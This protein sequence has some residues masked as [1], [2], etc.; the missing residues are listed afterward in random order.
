M[1]APTPAGIDAGTTVG[2]V[3]LTVADLQRSLDYYTTSIG[4]RVIERTGSDARLGAGGGDHG[5]AEGLLV[6]DEQPGARPAGSYAGLYHFALLLPDRPSLARWLLHAAEDGVVVG[7][8][9]DHT[10]SEALYLTDPDGHGIEIYRDRPREQWEGRVS[11]LMSTLPLDLDG[12]IAEAS[13]HRGT[14]YPGMPAQTR[15]GHIHLQVADIG[16]TLDFY[17]GV[18]GFEV[19]ARYGAAAAFFGAGGYHHHVGANVWHS[20]GRPVAPPGHATLR[21]ATIVVPGDAELDR[22]EASLKEAGATAVRDEGGLDVADPSG[23]PLRL[24]AAS[25]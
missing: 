10:V 20:R 5:S 2:E 3:W 8:A 23:I 12:L 15:M 9:S 18:L 4:L 21:R 16:P 25:S 19:M 14:P 22:L 11:E 13:E 24:Q 1:A 17:G 6:L 7:G